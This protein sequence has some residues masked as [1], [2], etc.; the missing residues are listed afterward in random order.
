[1]KRGPM[2]AGT[3]LLV[4]LLWAGRLAAATVHVPADVPTIAAGLDVVEPGDTVLVAAGT[5][6]EYNLELPSR[7]TLL[8]ASGI[9]ATVIDAQGDGRVLAVRSAVAGTRI[10]NFTLT[11][12]RLWRPSADAAGLW[13]QSGSTLT[14]RDC[15]IVG[16]NASGSTEL[17]AMGAGVVDSWVTFE[18]CSFEENGT[19]ASSDGSTAGLGCWH[20][21]VSLTDCEFVGNR[22]FQSPAGGLLC[23]DGSAVVARGCL[24]RDNWATRHGAIAVEES[25]LELRDCVLDGNA[26]TYEG[27]G[28]YTHGAELAIDNCL[29]AGGHYADFG[30]GLLLES[31]SV[32]ITGSTITRNRT[33]DGAWPGVP[34]GGLRC[35]G[36]TVSVSMSVI[37]GNCT[38]L[39]VGNDAQVVSGSLS[40]SCCVVNPDTVAGAAS[41]LDGCIAQDPDFCGPAGCGQGGGDYR[42]DGASV[43]LPA[44]ND[45]GARL[46]AFGR[47]CGETGVERSSWSAVKS[48]Y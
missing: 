3:A 10:E 33:D 43:C 26:A 47:G 6:H 27:G 41:F 40:F 16:N 8:G 2:T 12:G 30:G 48:R 34:G 25:D 46:G 23:R 37:W 31:S 20:S 5:Y 18:R 4:A 11:G 21:I 29:I 7:V 42:V 24:F 14:V 44:L 35:L 17:G 13:V 9:D 39:G 38:D 36:S 15:R 19:G 28:I 32:T 45:C 1:M 22:G